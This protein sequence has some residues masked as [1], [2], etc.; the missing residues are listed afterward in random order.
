MVLPYIP[1]PPSVPHSLLSELRKV[2][3]TTL[4]P[5]ALGWG[6]GSGPPAPPWP[7]KG[8]H[9]AGSTVGCLRQTL[10]VSRGKRQVGEIA[11]AAPF[12]VQLAARCLAKRRASLIRAGVWRGSGFTTGGPISCELCMGCGRD[13]VADPWG[14]A[15]GPR[16]PVWGGAQ[17][18]VS[19]HTLPG[20]S[21][22]L[23][24]FPGCPESPSTALV[25]G[26]GA[27]CPERQA[28]PSAGPRQGVVSGRRLKAHAGRRQARWRCCPGPGR[29]Q[30]FL[31]PQ[32]RVPASADP[33]VPAPVLHAAP[34]H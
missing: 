15:R 6:W 4:S 33:A 3:V 9:L 24:P 29:A 1:D 8:T 31:S 10:H 16:G 28:P 32:P 22:G 18:A 26:R 30:C 13:P 20:S 14:S 23:S 12:R 19:S 5:E 27:C 7:L 17:G 21:G 34:L 11:E 2:P 25:V